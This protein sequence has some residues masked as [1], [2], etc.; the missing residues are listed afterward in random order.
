MRKINIEIKARCDDPGRVRA[1]L[2][3]RGARS[4]GTDHQRDTY[5]RV[6]AG[7]LQLRQGNIEKA[8]IYYIT[9]APTRPG[10]KNPMFCS[11]R[12]VTAKSCAGY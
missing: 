7:R 1:A 12:W 8:L 2:A 5:F 4:A 9:G 3:A 6:P 11:T 10:R